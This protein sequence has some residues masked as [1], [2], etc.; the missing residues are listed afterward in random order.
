MITISHYLHQ[1]KHYQEWFEIVTQSTH[2]S[3]EKDKLSFYASKV[4]QLEKDMETPQAKRLRDRFFALE[5][6]L[7]YK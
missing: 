1:K 6:H 5:K 2:K 4:E 7:R 3:R